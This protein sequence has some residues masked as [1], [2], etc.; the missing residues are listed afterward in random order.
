MEIMNIQQ[1]I[2]PIILLGALCIG[3]V[4]KNWMPTD[5]RYIPLILM[6]FG[7]ISGV[8]LL[9]FSYES[10]VKGMISGLA[11]V[12]LNQVFKQ[13]MKLPMDADELLN[14]GKGDDEDEEI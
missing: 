12:G 3:Y 2:S 8:I 6:I 4:L 1:Y 7:G 5:N 14:M 11:A 10:V 13:Y 9:G